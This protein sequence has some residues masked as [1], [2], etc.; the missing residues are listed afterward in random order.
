M[1]P[2][3][4]TL[5]FIIQ[6]NYEMPIFVRFPMGLVVREKKVLESISLISNISVE[7]QGKTS[8]KASMGPAHNERNRPP[9]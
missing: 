1:I 6:I 7:F 4:H 8:G 3:I 2:I 9:M 5:T